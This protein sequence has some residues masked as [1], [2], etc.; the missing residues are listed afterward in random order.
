M[1]WS[2][3]LHCTSL[4]YLVNLQPTHISFT[5][6]HHINHSSNPLSKSIWFTEDTPYNFCST[7]GRSC[8]Q[9]NISQ[10]L[11]FA[12]CSWFSVHD[13]PCSVS[14]AVVIRH[15]QPSTPLLQSTLWREHIYV[16]SLYAATKFPI[17]IR[18]YDTEIW[19]LS[20]ATCPTHVFFP[21]CTGPSTQPHIQES[22][23]LVS[24]RLSF[25]YYYSPFLNK[26]ILKC[27]AL[28]AFFAM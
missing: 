20:F 26:R 5:S 15:L 8:S 22:D 28:Q 6:L 27:S 21:P 25:W 7:A 11:T 10:Y 14:W 9:R 19:P 4:H 1:P 18:L 23:I 13:Q 2:T 17:S 3:S 24:C 16:M 12:T